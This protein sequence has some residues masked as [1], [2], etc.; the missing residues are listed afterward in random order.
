MSA[1]IPYVK[2]VEIYKKK[3]YAIDPD[4]LTPVVVER[5]HVRFVG[6]ANGKEWYCDYISGE[7]PPSTVFMAWAADKMKSRVDRLTLQDSE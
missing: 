2:S 5:Y 3:Q 1:E 6:I 4:T 7:D